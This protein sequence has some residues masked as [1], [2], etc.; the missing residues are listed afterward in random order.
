MPD[1]AEHSVIPET[2]DEALERWDD[3]RP[4]FTVEMGG[5]GPGY[6][7]VIHIA[8]F[9]L[10]RR[11]KDEDVPD[12]EDAEEDDWGH[13]ELHEIDREKELGLS[14]AQA[15][16]ARFLAY[17]YLHEG[18]GEALEQ[19]PEDRMIQVSKSTPQGRTGSPSA[20]S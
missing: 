14:G 8:V 7:Q 12:P 13:D 19:V 16:A 1:A 2:V 4:V 18:Y 15:G 11:K 20:G 6:E 10:L 17:R 3:G 5:L 9:E